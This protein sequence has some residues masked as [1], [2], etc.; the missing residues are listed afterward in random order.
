MYVGGLNFSS[1][2]K[3]EKSMHIFV[4]LSQFKNVCERRNIYTYF[5]A[6]WEVGNVR[7][8][9]V[10]VSYTARATFDQHASVCETFRHDQFA[11]CRR[12]ARLALVV[13]HLSLRIL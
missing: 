13:H 12:A 10:H 11:P 6:A 1:R 2:L 7:I 8:K 4:F 9:G 5:L 3:K